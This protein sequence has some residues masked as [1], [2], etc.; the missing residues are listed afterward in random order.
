MVEYYAN[1]LI[2][3]F[4]PTI[5]MISAVQCMMNQVHKNK[6]R[7]LKWDMMHAV[8]VTYIIPRCDRRSRSVAEI[9]LFN[10]DEIIKS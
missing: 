3:S 1:Y 6:M 8:Q 2:H 4:E 10:H 7:R 5:I 9:A